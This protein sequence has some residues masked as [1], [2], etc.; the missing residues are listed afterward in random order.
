[1]TGVATL[2]RQCMDLFQKIQPMFTDPRPGH[3]WTGRLELA[4][5]VQ[6]IEGWM[7]DDCTNLIEF[8]EASKLLD[9]FRS[10]PHARYTVE[11]C[12]AALKE[13]TEKWTGKKERAGKR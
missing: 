2:N 11:E 13:E 6:R 7:R 10:L 4:G 8:S 12:A 3:V 5:I 9:Y 1:M